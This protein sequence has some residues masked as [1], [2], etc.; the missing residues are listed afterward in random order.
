MGL[1]QSGGNSWLQPELLESIC[2]GLVTVSEESGGQSLVL[3][4]AIETLI[5]VFRAGEPQHH[6]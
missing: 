1:L 2:A 6:E 3:L 4:G 5:C